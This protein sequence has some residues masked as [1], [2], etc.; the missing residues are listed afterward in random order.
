MNGVS[1]ALSCQLL[2]LSNQHRQ[3]GVGEAYLWCRNAVVP[4]VGW[5]VLV[6]RKCWGEGYIVRVRKVV[7]PVQALFAPIN[8]IAI[9]RD[10]G[11]IKVQLFSDPQSNAAGEEE[12]PFGQPGVWAVGPDP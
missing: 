4:D 3:V 7:V 9:G 12:L 10:Q 8:F 1:R 5:H 11:R 6:V 2:N